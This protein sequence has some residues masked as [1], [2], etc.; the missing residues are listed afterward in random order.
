MIEPPSH[1]DRSER[2]DA[3]GPSHYGEPGAAGATS[4]N[5]VLACFAEVIG[6]F[7][8]VLVGTA[9]A[10]AAVLGKGTA[11][12]AYDSLSVALSFGLILIPIVG[13][14]GQISGAHVNPA[15]TFGLAVAGKF[16]W[17]DVL[18]YWA[19]QLAGAIIAAVVVWAAYGHGAYADAHLGAPSPANGANALQVLLVEALIA[20]ILVFTVIS[21][22]TD[23]RVPPGTAAMVIG[24]A[25]AAGVL[26]GGPVSGGAGNP[27]RALG[28]MI[29]AGTFPVWLFYCAGP[30]LDGGVAA[31][32][33]RLV[34][35]ATTPKVAEA[36]TSI[37][38][39][40]T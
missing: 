33:F 18:P 9:V 7:L 23:K 5:L 36:G 34:G 32:V 4:S 25:L 26:L 39:K 22:T 14:L 2:N 20:F 21:T 28:P 29:V 10:T 30:L 8:L 3:H 11:G 31:L 15:V 40:L 35:M 13:S 27:A 6:T 24:F 1:E 38:Q 37:R 17:K 16:P 12:P 19:A